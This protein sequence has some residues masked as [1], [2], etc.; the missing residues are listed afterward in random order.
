[1]LRNLFVTCNA[2][3]RAN[4]FGSIRRNLLIFNNV[5]EICKQSLQSAIVIFT[6]TLS[7]LLADK[8]NS[9]EWR[10]AKSY[11]DTTNIFRPFLSL[12]LEIVTYVTNEMRG[13]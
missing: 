13:Y 3:I 2:S 4:D 11:L 12:L 5:S 6:R 9:S 8:G 1:M 7:E 10:C